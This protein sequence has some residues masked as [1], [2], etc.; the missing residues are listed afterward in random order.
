MMLHLKVI[1]VYY[2]ISP[3]ISSKLAVFPGD[4]AFEHKISLSFAQGKNIEL[5][6]ILSSVHVGAHADA[7]SHYHASGV[8]IEKRSLSYYLGPCEVVNVSAVLKRQG[9]EQRR[10]L[11]NDLPDGENFKAKTQRVLFKTDSFLDLTKWTHEFISLSPQLIDFFNKQNVILMGID[12]P[13]VDPSNSK[14]LPS[15]NALFRANMAVLEGLWLKDINPG[16]YNLIALPLNLEGV[17]ASPV[18]AIL[19]PENYSF[20]DLS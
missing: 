16:I 9:E 10:I 11:V 8:S 13:S 17:E 18:R 15:H 14:D 5:S 1:M 3:K 20:S 7:P 19:L 2:D 6:S 4:Q 12:T